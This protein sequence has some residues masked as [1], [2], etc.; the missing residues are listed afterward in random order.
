[1]RVSPA[2]LFYVIESSISDVHSLICFISRVSYVICVFSTRSKDIATE[3]DCNY[4][5][6]D[7]CELFSQFKFPIDEFFQPNKSEFEDTLGCDA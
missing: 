5:V 7:P 4:D 6:D 3:C 2:P 1:M